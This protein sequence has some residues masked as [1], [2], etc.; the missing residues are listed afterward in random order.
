MA[1]RQVGIWLD[2]Q[3][4]RQ[5]G[6]EMDKQ[7]SR[8]TNDLTKRHGDSLGGRPAGRQASWQQCS[9]TCKQVGRQANIHGIRWAGSRHAGK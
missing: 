3:A 2:R 9:E 4:G 6:S 7:T 1:G 8:E 5:T